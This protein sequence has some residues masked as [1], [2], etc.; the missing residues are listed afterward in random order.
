MQISEL[1][2]LIDVPKVVQ[3]KVINY[4]N[5]IHLKSIEAE[6]D[7]MN[8]P[9]TWEKAVDDLTKFLAPDETGLKL[10]TCQLYAACYTYEEYKNRGI[11]D[12]N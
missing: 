9:N 10:L 1:C 2:N 4:E 6:I 11:S 3:D 8:N 12:D 7:Q 5:E